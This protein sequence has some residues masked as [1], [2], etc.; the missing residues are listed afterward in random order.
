MAGKDV[1]DKLIF[2]CDRKKKQSLAEKGHIWKE[3]GVMTQRRKDK[4][5]GSLLRDNDKNNVI[6]NKSSY[7]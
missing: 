1:S 7:F 5:L 3:S 4:E 2:R 6:A